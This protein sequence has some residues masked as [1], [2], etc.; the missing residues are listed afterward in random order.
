MIATCQYLEGSYGKKGDRLFSRVCGDR[1]RGN[2]F[3]LK[4]RRFRLDIRKKSVTVRMVR[5]WH[6][7]PRDVVDAS[8]TETFKARLIRPWAT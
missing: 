4:E 3:K 7:L 5:H 2:G 1:T 8:S 6:R